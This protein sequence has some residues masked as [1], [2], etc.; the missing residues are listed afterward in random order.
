MTYTNTHC[1]NCANELSG[2]YCSECGQKA[3]TH[4]ITFRNFVS[5]DLLHGT[6]HIEK[7]ILFTAKEA[8]IRPGK[9][10][11][12]YISGKR[13]RYYNVFLLCLITFGIVLFVRH[14]DH[15]FA[16]SNL[17]PKNDFPNEAS[18]KLDEIVSS[19]IFIFLFIPFSSINSFILFR[20]RRLNLSEHFII[21]GIILLGILLISIFGNLL[22][23]LTELLGFDAMMLRAILA[24]IT[25]LY[26]CYAYINA[27]GNLY[28]IF[29]MVWRLLT[30]LLFNAIEA[31]FLILL[32]FGFLTNWE[33]GQLTFDPF[34]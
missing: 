14:L 11:L 7:G 15:L 10:A 27:F 23:G 5:H 13:K 34:G 24:S 17:L 16:D 6:F 3:D 32:L 1:L 20:R 25:I 19:K 8:L 9:A 12:D 30:Y 33:F 26:I 4:R 21:A 29:G 18:R 22:S 28:S 31:I 2:K